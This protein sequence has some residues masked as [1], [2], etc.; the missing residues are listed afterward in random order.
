MIIVKAYTPS[1]KSLWDNFVFQAKN[2]HFMFCRD[3]MEYH[4]DRFSDFSLM[5]F[6][7]KKKL[8]AIL[9]ANISG[10]TIYSHQG[11]TF[12]GLITNINQTT[13]IVYEIFLALIEFLD[14][15]NV[16]KIIYKRIPDF[17]SINPSQEDL[18]A[19]FLLGARIIR[20]D[21]TVSI[22]LFNPLPV[23][24]NRLGALK[25][26][27]NS[28]LLI[29]E[30]HDLSL[31]WGVL[32]ETLMQQHGAKPAHTIYE[33]ELL[34]SR[35]PNFIK[36]FVAILNDEVLAGAVVYETP[37][38]AHTQ[39]LANTNYGKRIGALDVLLFELITN[40]YSSKHYFDFGTSNEADGK[41]L[42]TGLIAYKESFG[43]R[44]FVHEF[45]EICVHKKNI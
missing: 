2:G 34:K 33:I 5:F 42:N 13:S 44:A 30:I 7:Y 28:Q 45:Y 23:K 26:G 20:R 40:V 36:C 9:P 38:V 27:L 18:Y 15:C 10:N 32:E 1:D 11:L 16:D 25:K 8:I 31:F 41:Y 3:Y 37:I 12:G 35:F 17:Y 24:K 22:D 43:S 21:V 6:D 29:N 4:S 19:L 14:K 39:Y